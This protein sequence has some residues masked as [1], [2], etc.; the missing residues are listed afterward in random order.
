MIKYLTQIKS[1]IEALALVGQIV[2]NDEI[3]L[4]MLDRLGTNFEGFVASASWKL[5]N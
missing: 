1:L 3:V 4:V 2:M 5:I